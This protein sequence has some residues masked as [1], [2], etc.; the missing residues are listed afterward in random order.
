MKKR[1]FSKTKKLVALSLCALLA[2]PMTFVGCGDSDEIEIDATKTQLYV[3]I[4]DG[5]FGTEWL[6]NVATRFEAAYANYQGVDGKV[7]VQIV[8]DA[9]KNKVADISD[10]TGS[11][12]EIFMIEQFTKYVEYANAGAFLDITD[13]VT[14]QVDANKT[15]YNPNGTIVGRLTEEQE[16]YYNVNGKYYGIPHYGKYSG[17]SYD[18]D[19]FERA[20]PLCLYLDEE[21]KFVTDASDVSLR[22]KGPDNIKGT[23]DDGLP[24]TYDEF[25]KVMDRMVAT[26][27]TPFIWSGFSK[28]YYASTLSGLQANADGFDDYRLN[29]TFD[30]TAHNIVNSITPG[31]NFENTVVD[32][33]EEKI[34][35][36]N[37]YLMANSAGKYYAIKFLEKIVTNYNKYVYYDSF[38]PSHS[39]L[40]AQYDFIASKYDTTQKQIAMIIEG[41]WWENEI[42][43]RMDDMAVIYGE[44]AS[45]YNRNFAFMPMPI[46]KALSEGQTR[47]NIVLSTGD[48]HTLINSNIDSSKIELAKAFV[49]FFY[50]EEELIDFTVTT[51]S[52]IGVKYEMPEDKVAQLSSYGRS[53]ATVKENSKILYKYAPTAI[54]QNN[55][56]ALEELNGGWQ[57]EVATSLGN[58]T[59]VD[60]MDTF[61]YDN[62][63]AEDYFEGIV[64]KYGSTWWANNI[65]R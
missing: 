40:D 12:N 15:D 3:R 34:T 43:S 27:I 29:Y 46:P 48:T 24:A 31:S 10:I 50:T 2:V 45:R 17:I 39:H 64:R 55:V 28:G 37:G 63:S 57:A 9:N 32:V 8:P 59:K 36:D 56:S 41:T 61:R 6:T 33:R 16:E 38:S 53:L 5:G 25:F 58:V 51:N 14:E 22:S 30:G 54:F 18:V 62:I 44:E 7:G 11:R 52:M 21:G 49:R 42:S 26:N 1:D 19:V 35:A 60:V 4:H 23:Y 65:R 13:V 20:H 47:Q